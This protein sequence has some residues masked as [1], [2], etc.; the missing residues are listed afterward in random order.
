MTGEGDVH[1]GVAAQLLG[2]LDDQVAAGHEVVHQNH[3]GSLRNQ[4]RIFLGFAREADDVVAALLDLAESLG[5]AGHGLGHHDGLH[6]GIVGVLHDLLDDGF[7]LLGEVVGID[8]GGDHVAILG[9][10]HHGGGAF[11]D[12]LGHGARNHGDLVALGFGLRRRGHDHGQ[13]HCDGQQR[14]KHL[15]H[16]SSS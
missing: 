8:V 16:V 5:G 15:L 12:G 3:V 14:A 7:L 9:L 2:G 11:V 4:G 10:Q 13:D 6:V 1:E